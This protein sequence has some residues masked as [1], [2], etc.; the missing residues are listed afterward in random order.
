MTST[1]ARVGEQKVLRI[2][3]VVVTAERVGTEPPRD[4]CCGDNHV[5]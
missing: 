4:A 5:G 1:I 3:T 2:E